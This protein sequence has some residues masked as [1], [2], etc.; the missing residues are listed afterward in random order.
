MKKSRL[1]GALCV[2]VILLVFSAH[3]R[4]AVVYDESISGDLSNLSTDPVLNFSTGTNTII[5]NAA[6][7]YSSSPSFDIDNFSFVIPVDTELTSMTV[8]FSN[9]SLFTGTTQI[10]TTYFLRDS[11]DSPAGNSLSETITESGPITLHM[12]GLPAGPDTYRLITTGG[13]DAGNGGSYDY[14][15]NFNVTAVPVPAA[16]WLLAV[17]FRHGMPVRRRETQYRESGVRMT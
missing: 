1:V 3:T 8:E 11:T 17:R 14:R 10:A 6:L 13:W 12:T 9:I 7:T 2:P 4:A 15:L 16:A 5:G